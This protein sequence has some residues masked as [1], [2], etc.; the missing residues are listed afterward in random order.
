MP[1]I[2][3]TRGTLLVPIL[4]HIRNLGKNGSHTKILHLFF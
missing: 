4:V 1:S 2:G 3:K